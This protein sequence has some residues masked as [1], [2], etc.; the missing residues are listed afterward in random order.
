MSKALY[1][2]YRPISLDTVVGQ[3]AVV[4]SLQTA[5]RQGKINH[6]YL[7]TGPRGCGKTSVARIFAHAI[8]HFDYQLEDSYVDIIEIDA[9]SNRGIDNIRELR[10]KA[11]I[12][13]TTGQ[14]KVYII[15]EVH[16]LTKE[17]FNALLKLLEEPPAHVVFI[18]ATTDP[19]KLPI[20]ITSR[21][22]TYVF[23]LADPATMQQHLRQLADAEK[24]D[25]TDDALAIIVRRGG[26]SFRDSISLLDQIST[27][28]SD[29]I[30]ADTVTNALG[31]P[32]AEAVKQLLASYQS[33]DATAITAQLKDILN[34]GTKPE[35]LVEDLISQILEQPTP[36][37]YPLLAQLPTVQPP[38]TE[39]KL[40]LAL[41]PTAP[42]TTSQQGKAMA[43]APTASPPASEQAHISD[44]GV[45][46]PRMTSTRE[47][48]ATEI[49][50]D[51]AATTF[52]WPNF[53]SA[54]SSTALSNY[55][56]KSQ[57]YV[58]GST[59]HIYPSQK[60]A[61]RILNSPNNKALLQ[62]HAG[63]LQ[64]QIHDATD[65]PP[66]TAEPSNS[67]QFSQISDIMGTVQE[68]N[69]DAGSIP[70]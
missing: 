68:V 62:E 67:S 28:S 64:V 59:L 13:P 2:K 48:G 53:L 8:N 1:R 50:A 12:A 34:S 26:G 15:D 32:H 70:F 3:D 57:H 65:T 16:M 23:K 58:D 35:V 41:L 36:P 52:S 47:S 6:A 31:L 44:D 38:F 61:T 51:A 66:T 10:E 11:T 29:Q 7:F 21:A 42:T 27:L 49:S 9:A 40:L 20:T 37:L 46:A 14:Y 60:I 39:A 24:L 30:T 25:I 45:A 55:L 69:T 43:A 17:A 33:S 22:Q 4:Q 63:G 54:L 56:Q 19:Q 5:I 18:M